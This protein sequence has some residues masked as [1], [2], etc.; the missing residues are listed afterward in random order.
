MGGTGWSFT[1][2]PSENNTK[3][4]GG[5]ASPERAVTDLGTAGGWD[6]GA[7]FWAGNDSVP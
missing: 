4:G 5:H 6:E 7:S 3:Q 2:F 1:T